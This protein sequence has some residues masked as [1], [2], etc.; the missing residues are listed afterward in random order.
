M[1]PIS[2]IRLENLE[3]LVKEAGTADMLAECSGL[4]PVYISQIRGRAI[5]RKTGKPR[6]L[7]SAA[8]RKL[9]KGMN[10]AL[11]WMD[12][13]HSDTGETVV[14]SY[15]PF[16]RLPHSD[17]ERLSSSQKEAIEDW[18]IAQVYTFLTPIQP[19]KNYLAA[20]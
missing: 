18:V 12:K 4:S 2:E 14:C 1:K 16:P 15:W 10:K 13:D 20:R 8:A 3:T 17:Y 6:N 5:D 11:G 9:E 19:Q 7:G